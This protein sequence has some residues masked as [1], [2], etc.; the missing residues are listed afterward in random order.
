MEFQTL[1]LNCV[2]CKSVPFNG[3]IREH[4]KTCHDYF[5]VQGRIQVG[6]VDPNEAPPHKLEIICADCKHV[7]VSRKT[8]IV[9]DFFKE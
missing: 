6:A 5:V 9:D 2:K 4:I 8:T 3:I 1:D 7:W